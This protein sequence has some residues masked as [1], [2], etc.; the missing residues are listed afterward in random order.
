MSQYSSPANVHDWFALTSSTAFQWN[1]IISYQMIYNGGI[2][3][4]YVVLLCSGFD[5]G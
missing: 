1:Y 2:I 3:E 5:I 4:L